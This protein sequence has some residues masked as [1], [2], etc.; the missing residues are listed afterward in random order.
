M[1]AHR[2]LAALVGKAHR[3]DMKLSLGSVDSSVWRIPVAVLAMI[4]GA[5]LI[6]LAGRQVDAL[7]IA[8]PSDFVYNHELLAN[9]A[10]GEFFKTT[11]VHGSGIGNADHFSPSLL[12]LVP[13]FLVS[14][15]IKLTQYLVVLVLIITIIP[16]YSLAH[17]V[18]GTALAACLAACGFL[19]LP[20]LHALA[21]NG[22]W[23]SIM[24]IPALAW[25]I[26]FLYRGNLGGFLAAGTIVMMSR[27]EFFII[28]GSFAL[29]ELC[30]SRRKRFIIVPLVMALLYGGVV[31]NLSGSLGQDRMSTTMWFLSNHPLPVKAMAGHLLHLIGSVSPLLLLA[32]LSPARLIPAAPAWCIAAAFLSTAA[33]AAALDYMPG[34]NDSHY[35][36]A[37]FPILVSAAITGAARLGKLT[38][39]PGARSLV[40]VI[41]LSCYGAQA[42]VSIHR[43]RNLGSDHF[44]PDAGDRLLWTVDTMLPYG[45]RILSN[46]PIP[47]VFQSHAGAF[48]QAADSADGQEWVELQDHLLD[49]RMFSSEDPRQFLET[50]YF[51]WN[52]LGVSY[53]PLRVGEAGNA[54]WT[55]F[56][57]PI[58]SF[59][60]IHDV[61]HNT[62]LL[63]TTCLIPGKIHVTEAK[64]HHTG[65]LG[66]VSATRPNLRDLRLRARSPLPVPPAELTRAILSLSAMT[67]TNNRASVLF[68]A[69]PSGAYTGAA[70]TCTGE[71]MAEA[72][73]LPLDSHQAAPIEAAS[74]PLAAFPDSFDVADVDGDGSP[75]WIIVTGDALVLHLGSVVSKT[76][77]PGGEIIAARFFDTGSTTGIAAAGRAG[78]LHLYRL[79][80]GWE[81]QHCG[82]VAD[83][84]YALDMVCMDMDADGDDDLFVYDLETFSIKYYMQ[85][86]G[87]FQPIW[88]RRIAPLART[89]ALADMDGDGLLDLAA[90]RSAF[91]YNRYELAA[92]MRACDIDHALVDTSGAGVLERWLRLNGWQER[93]VADHVLLFRRSP[94]TESRP[95]STGD[96]LKAE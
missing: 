50:G 87:D 91:L 52:R 45:A 22:C 34:N 24:V 76:R 36:L 39:R 29:T 37:V 60:S 85:H 92:C 25:T 53:L 7:S 72:R 70:I 3:R 51:D 18:F 58:D 17:R 82:T 66:L 1:A 73:L 47:Y 96:S 5:T 20:E 31:L 80:S 84:G 46:L 71:G 2:C 86:E 49:R 13:F 48:L 83:V 32:L 27:E 94:H 21:L 15:S 26:T 81:L 11:M 19:L 77:Q 78:G 74:L 10:R 95:S 88:N 30:T 35:L 56:P 9:T 6:H 65:A 68:L 12:L 40:I 54:A 64:V 90:A 28:V 44:S 61:S 67:G 42:L 62:R 79:D 8:K 41:L 14:T 33:P 63:F 59:I 23:M 93:Q 55:F 16:V 4:A 43:I 38:S 75:D 57:T 69:D 89:L